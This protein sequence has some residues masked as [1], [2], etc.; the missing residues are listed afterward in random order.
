MD[1]PYH[2]AFCVWHREHLNSLGAGQKNRTPP[3]R[4]TPQISNQ[5]HFL[6]RGEPDP[7][8]GAY[9]KVGGTRDTSGCIVRRVQGL[10][11]G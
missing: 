1:C 2:K 11:T 10:G 7:G 6:P 9:D 8:N 4:K 5:D 3:Q